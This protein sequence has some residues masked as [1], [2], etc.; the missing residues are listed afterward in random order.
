M[1]WNLDWNEFS[2]F[3]LRFHLQLAPWMAVEI[4]D[5]IEKNLIQYKEKTE[6]WMC[7]FYILI[8]CLFNYARHTTRLE[9]FKNNMFHRVSVGK[10][11]K[12]IHWK[13]QVCILIAS[14]YAEY[15]GSRIKEIHWISLLGDGDLKNAKFSRTL[16]QIKKICFERLSS[17]NHIQTIVTKSSPEKKSH[18]F[19]DFQSE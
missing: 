13:S 14:S 16:I 1:N 3:F 9:M 19:Y 12:L 10:T 15:I 4:P 8:K 18:K 7:I 11:W 2:H 17:T 5:M 6:V